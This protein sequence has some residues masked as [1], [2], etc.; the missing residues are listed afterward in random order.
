[1]SRV[2]LRGGVLAIDKPVGPT[3][4]DVVARARRALGDRRVGHTGTLDPFAS[5]LLLLCCGPATRLSQFLTGSDKSYRAAL[6]FGSAT[7]TLDLQGEIV[8]RDDSWRELDEDRIRAAALTFVGDQMQTPPAYSAKKV[9]GEAAHRRVRRGEEVTLKPVPVHIASLEVVEVELPRVVFDVTVSAGTFIRTLADDL[10][11]SLGSCGHLTELRR[12]RVGTVDLVRAIT[13]EELDSLVAAPAD[14]SD[15][16][17]DWITPLEAV[18]HLPQCRV[19]PEQARRLSFG[20]RIESSA[21]D[22]PPEVQ[23]GTLLSAQLEGELLGMVE[24]EAGCIRPRKIFLT[25]EEIAQ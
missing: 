6:L 14:S 8:E 1:V 18:G 7:D 10:A 19:T 20:Q 23:P 21:F 17:L 22:L 11:R 4:H 3:S 12:T 2:P 13:L 15:S 25:P 5:G 16:G 9:D 24:L